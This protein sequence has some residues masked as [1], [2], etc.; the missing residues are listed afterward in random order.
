MADKDPRLIFEPY[1]RDATSEEQNQSPRGNIYWC[2]AL[3]FQQSIRVLNLH[4]HDPYHKNP[5]LFLLDKEDT[6]AFQDRTH[7]PILDPPLQADEEL[8]V[9]SA[10]RRP[11][12]LLS[13]HTETWQ[14]RS[15]ATRD[16]CYLVAPVFSF[17]DGDDEI[18]KAKTWAFNYREIF[19]LPEDKTLRIDEGIVRFDRIQVVPRRW[20]KKRHVA[21]TPDVLAVL[22]SWFQFYLTG[23]ADELTRELIFPH[24]DEVIAKIE[25]KYG[26]GNMQSTSIESRTAKE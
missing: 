6:N 26:K 11:A 17:H 5:T 20:L 24:R 7:K 12:I 3:Y 9:F 10:K 19:Y 1:Y 13:S 2:P 8:V 21:L 18:W 25:E 4:S 16:E 23:I 22:T 15:G 14:L